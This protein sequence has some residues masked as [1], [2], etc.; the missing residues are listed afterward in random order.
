MKLETIK[1]SV[2]IGTLGA[3]AFAEGCYTPS[4]DTSYSLKSRVSEVKSN[5]DKEE[6]ERIIKKQMIECEDLHDR[7]EY[8]ISLPPWRKFPL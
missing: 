7:V 2:I 1:K 5:K 3:L 8:H 6:R 4:P